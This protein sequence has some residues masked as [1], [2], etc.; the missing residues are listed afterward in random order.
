MDLNAHEDDPLWAE[1]LKIDCV[2]LYKV[3]ESYHDLVENRLGGEVGMTSP[4]TS[5]KLFRRRFM[6]QGN[7]PAKIPRHQHFPGCVDAGCK[8]CA[9]EW[10]R[11]AYYGGR[12]EI[13]ERYGEGL[14]YYDLNSSYVAA[15]RETMPAGDRRV[16]DSLDWRLH[17]DNVGF[18]E[19]TVTIPETCVLPPLPYRSDT[20]KLI[21]PVGTF[22]G[23]WDTEELM[24]L[25]DPSVK[26]SISDVKKVVWYRRKKLFD[27]MVET[28][29]ALRDKSLPGYDEGLSVTAKLLGNSLYGKFGMNEERR[30]IVFRAPPPKGREE[31]VCAICGKSAGDVLCPDC[32][33]ST[34][35]NPKVDTG[36]WYQKKH[37]SAS[38]II[39]Q[40]AAHITTL[41]RVRLW[42]VMRM[43]LD[44][45]KT[46]F[47]GDTDS[48]LTDAILPCS[49]EL[50]A[51][52]DEYPGET[53]TCLAI[54]PKVYMIEKEK[55][56]KG[57]HETGCKTR[58]KEV[59]CEGCEKCHGCSKRKISMKGFPK[60]T[61]TKENLEI[62]QAGGTIQF[63][64][65]NK[66]RT[67]ARSGFMDGPSMKTD[68]KKS[69][70]TK[71]DKRVMLED[72]S[73]RP[74]VLSL[75]SVSP[76]PLCLHCGTDEEVSEIDSRFQPT[77]P[78]CADCH[79]AGADT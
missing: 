72:G 68:V 7:C 41:A 22:S 65:L 8:G 44:M 14:H 31:S 46:L 48:I 33:G 74:V 28:L 73:S 21:F 6:G 12:T 52:K 64:R 15:M 40:I 26:G 36:V 32:I 5:M 62:L 23:V 45:G 66:V 49:S 58:C 38:Y 55:P 50:G 37:V 71:Y 3:V 25:F 27:G 30:T 39:P 19:C 70:R 56:F 75:P 78:E 34:P 4:S 24:L 76:P 16:M 79:D 67:L 42:R 20:G 13:F 43:V 10:V 17:E 59:D 29:W 47:Y 1:Y 18:V 57:E 69:F 11:R 60:E 35:A 63:S 77:E 53:L 2:Q 9:Q 61:R 54:Q 51:L